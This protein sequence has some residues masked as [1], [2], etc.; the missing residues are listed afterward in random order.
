MRNLLEAIK[1]IQPEMKEAEKQLARKL[2]WKWNRKYSEM[3]GYVRRRMALAV[4]RANSLIPRTVP[5]H[6]FRTALPWMPG[7][8]GGRS[9]K[10]LVSEDWKSVEWVC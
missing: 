7:S 5:A 9:G 2:A 6:L 10:H 4:V 3:V 1:N 8:S